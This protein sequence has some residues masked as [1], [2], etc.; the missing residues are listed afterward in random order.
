[1]FFQ[2][3]Y[4]YTCKLDK[5]VTLGQ[6]HVTDL[7]RE[8]TYQILYQTDLHKISNQI[9]YLNNNKLKYKTT[10]KIIHYKK[11]FLR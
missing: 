3:S 10:Y 8:P 6:A 1:M 7:S 4:K 2:P 11:N 9:F 5:S